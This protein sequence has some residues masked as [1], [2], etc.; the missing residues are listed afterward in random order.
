MI[1]R[2]IQGRR[3]PALGFG[4]WELSPPAARDA[5]RD[6]LAIGYRHIDTA[7]AYDNEEGVGRGIADAAVPREEIFLTTKVRWERLSYGEVIASAEASLRRLG[8]PY[9]DL[10]LVH[11]PSTDVPFD[12]PLAAMQA[13]RAHGRVR[14][15]GVSNFTPSQLGRALDLAPVFCLQVEYHP[16]LSQ[17]D[18][19][20][21]AREHDL[22]FT[23][24]CPIARGEVMA[25]ETLQ[26]IGA[27]YGKTP[28][29]VTLRWLLQQ[30][31]VAAIPKA[32]SAGHRRENFAVFD[33][34][35][36][37]DDMRAIHALDR[38]ARIIDPAHAPQ[39][40][41]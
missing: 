18:L 14:H 25:D 4:T 33:F 35:L 38:E 3:V 32:G 30:K 37:D 11:W 22:L 40:E 19:L 31:N 8:T 15:L 7:Q 27:R 10:L 34:E 6:A 13:L 9:V 29:Q 20:A 1:Y 21:I 17:R 12:E 23:A 36:S 24:Y 39:W 26:A 41:R 5:V 16:Y 28:A 2:D